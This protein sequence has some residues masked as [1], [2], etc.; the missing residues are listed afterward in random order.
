MNAYISSRRFHPGHF[1]HMH[2]NYLMLIDL[3]LNPC[4]YVNSGF[5][6]MAVNLERINFFSQL[7]ADKNFKYLIVWFPSIQSLFDML[8]VRLFRKNKVVIYFFHEPYDS[9][10][11]YLHSGFGILKTIKITLVSL[12]NFFLVAL[13]N[14]VILPSDAALQKYENNYTWLNK[15]HIRIPLLFGD[16]LVGPING[17]LERQFISYVGTI[18]EDHAFDEFVSLV[19]RAAE[20]NMFPR[21]RFLIAT[22]ST[23]PDWAMERLDKAISSGKLVVYFGQPL[24]NEEINGYYHSSVVVWNAYRR[25]MQSGVMPKAFMFGT[26]VLVSNFNQSEFFVNHENGELITQY[27]YEITVLAISN[28]IANFSFYSKCSREAF[29][30]YYFYRAHTQEFLEFISSSKESFA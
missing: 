3:G 2:A 9:F 25:S 24:T 16:E 7:L 11:A 4:L 19:S 14:K 10:F 8:F 1:S 22:R 21:L 29:L 28:I 26:P 15:P 27:N 5:N 17:F 18:A 6:K 13:S 20:E 23:P 12:F 30:K